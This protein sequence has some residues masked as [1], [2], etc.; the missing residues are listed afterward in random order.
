MDHGDRT[1]LPSLPRKN[2]AN[3]MALILAGVVV[4]EDINT[5]EAAREATLEVLYEEI[6]TADLGGHALT[7][8][9]ADEVIRCVRATQRRGDARLKTIERV[10]R[11]EALTTRN[12]AREQVEGE[13]PS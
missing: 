12:R 2:V 9:F 5:P 11:E 6:R 4:L 13:D 8:E 3:P 7:F 1:K 10:G